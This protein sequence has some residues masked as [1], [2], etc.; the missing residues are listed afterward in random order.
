VVGV[1]MFF[2]SV[3]VFFFFFVVSVLFGPNEPVQEIAGAKTGRENW[4]AK[5]RRKNWGG[6]PL[7]AGKA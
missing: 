7:F 2:L 1:T 3:W 6:A 5:T 4:G